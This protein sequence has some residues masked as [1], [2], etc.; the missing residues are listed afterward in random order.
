M[1]TRWVGEL[2]EVLLGFLA[3]AEEEFALA[4]FLDWHRPSQ[5]SGLGWVVVGLVEPGAPV[6]E[7]PKSF[8]GFEADFRCR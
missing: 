5:L 4:A 1:V 7:D 2:E 6:L 8:G 3:G